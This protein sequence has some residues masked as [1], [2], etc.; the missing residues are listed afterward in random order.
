MDTGEEG[1]KGRGAVRAERDEEL[2]LGF[3]VW[4]ATARD[5]GIAGNPAG[6]D[7]AEAEVEDDLVDPGPPWLEFFGEEGEGEAAGRAAVFDLRVDDRDDAGEFGTGRRW[8]SSGRNQDRDEGKPRGGKD[9]GRGAGEAWRAQ[10]PGG[11]RGDAHEWDMAAWPAAWRQCR[12]HCG[13][14]EENEI[15]RKTPCPKFL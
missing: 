5:G 14:E 9:A 11:P 13:G 3:R 15:S 7:A 4:S 8:R 1:E 6:G 12:R 10:P 2:T